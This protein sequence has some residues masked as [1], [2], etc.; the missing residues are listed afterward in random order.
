MHVHH[1]MIAYTLLNLIKFLVINDLDRD[2]LI[3]YI[4]DKEREQIRLHKALEN[5]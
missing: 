5:G 2:L 4:F 3:S 1:I